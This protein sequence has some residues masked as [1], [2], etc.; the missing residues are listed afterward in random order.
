MSVVSF[1]TNW[2]KSRVDSCKAVSGNDTDSINNGSSYTRKLVLR[3]EI[4][5]K[6]TGGS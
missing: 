6:L 5:V 2:N 1:I 3:F 4:I